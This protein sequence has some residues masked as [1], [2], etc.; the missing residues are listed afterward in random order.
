[1]QL[2]TQK[3]QEQWDRVPAH[4]RGGGTEAL[5]EILL[6]KMPKSCQTY[7]QFV[8]AMA[9]SKGEIM[10]DYQGIAKVLLT[11]QAD[12]DDEAEAHYSQEGGRDSNGRSS[13]GRKPFGAKPMGKMLC[14]RAG[15]AKIMDPSI[16]KKIVDKAKEKGFFSSWGSAS[17]NM[18]EEDEPLTVEEFDFYTSS[19]AVAL[20]TID[21]EVPVNKYA[22]GSSVIEYMSEQYLSSGRRGQRHQGAH[23]GAAPRS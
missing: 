20:M 3:L 11:Y 1:L 12:S 14:H 22:M 7:V 15:L 9:F 4:M 13:N 8:R 6:D 21:P 23:D 18:C 16:K 10:N 5:C 2:L 19:D 17:A